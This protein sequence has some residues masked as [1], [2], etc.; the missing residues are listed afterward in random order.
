[1][2][3]VEFVRFGA[4][5]L[6]SLIEEAEAVFCFDRIA[7]HAEQSYRIERRVAQTLI[8]RSATEAITDTARKLLVLRQDTA[9]ELE[10]LL[11]N[12]PE[13]DE[14]KFLKPADVSHGIWCE[15]FERTDFWHTLKYNAALKIPENNFSDLADKAD[16]ELR[17]H[18][19]F[20]TADKTDNKT[21][22]PT[23]SQKLYKLASLYELR[24]EF[25][26]K[27]WMDLTGLKKSTITSCQAFKD[28]AKYRALRAATNEEK[29]KGRS[30]RGRG[31]G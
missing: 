21:R 3:L 5:E 27:Q 17:S 25:T 18:H 8:Y 13:L 15:Q 2:K 4:N 19:R 12:C 14:F 9:D 11:E 22:P 7:E 20:K 16:A 29:R 1:M 26:F 28:F 30:T 24:R 10:Y 23:A 31:T 6:S